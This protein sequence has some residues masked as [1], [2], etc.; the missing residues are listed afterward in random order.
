MSELV[1]TPL[2]VA[3]ALEISDDN[4]LWLKQNAGLPYV[5]VG[6]AVWRVPW[7]ALNEWLATEVARN[8]LAKLDAQKAA[9]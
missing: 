7:F 9:S 5:M 3:E 6:R 4:V 1:G 2:Q 8:A